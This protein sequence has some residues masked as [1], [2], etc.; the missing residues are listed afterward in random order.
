MLAVLW[1]AVAPDGRMFAFRELC[2]PDLIVSEAAK[3]LLEVNRGLSVRATF[4]P[5][6]LWSRQKDSGRTVAELFEENGVLLTSVDNSRVSGWLTLAELL[7]PVLHRDA[8]TGG[9]SRRPRLMIFSCCHEL[10]RCLPLLQR[11]DSNPSDC[12]T[13]PHEITHVCDAARY[14]AVSRPSVPSPLCEDETALR[15]WRKRRL[16]GGGKRMRF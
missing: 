12:S 8:E 3:T 4:A 10:L 11:D 15:K 2:A 16:S 7:T 9:I 1:F 5:P 14:F 6:D 13:E